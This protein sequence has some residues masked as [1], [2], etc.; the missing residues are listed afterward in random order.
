MSIAERTY[1]GHI[2]VNKQKERINLVTLVI[3][4]PPVTVL[5]YQLAAFSAALK[6]EATHAMPK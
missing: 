6:I 2:S 4:T 5:M 3:S 1:I